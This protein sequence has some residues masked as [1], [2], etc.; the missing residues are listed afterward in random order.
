TSGRYKITLSTADNSLATPVTME[1]VIY[2][3]TDETSPV[4]DMIWSPTGDTVHTDKSRKLTW[5]YATD[6]PLTIHYALATSGGISEYGSFNSNRGF[7]TWE[8]TLPDNI[9]SCKINLVSYKNNNSSNITLSV[10]APPE[11][12][13][14]RIKAETF[15]NKVIPTSSETWTFYI[16]NEENTPQEAAVMMRMYNAA[17][18][19]LNQSPWTFP[20]R[21]DYIP[22]SV[23]LQDKGYAF[24]QT[25]D[26]VYLDLYRSRLTPI[27]FNTYGNPLYA[28]NYRIRGTRMMK[29]SYTANAV[30]ED[31]VAGNEVVAEMSATG[32]VMNDVE[33]E[34]SAADYDDGAATASAGVSDDS[35]SYRMLKCLSHSSCQC[36]KPTAKEG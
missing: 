36:S 20:K 30:V 23:R 24:S 25:S 29:A 17:L 15:R 32:R 11:E 26:R 6:E 13:P 21:Y 28:N 5:I 34:E 4:E 12:S 35:F 1:P 33:M 22:L 16:D 18:D 10:I 7:N 2:R 3:I 19:A 8:Y 27:S 9:E 14:L 31:F